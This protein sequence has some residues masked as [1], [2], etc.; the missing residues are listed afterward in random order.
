MAAASAPRPVLQEASGWQ[1]MAKKVQH[2]YDY[3][4]LWPII[5]FVLGF[6]NILFA[7]LGMIDFMVP[8]LLAL[9]GGNK[10]FCNRYCGRGLL[11]AKLGGDWKWS[12]NRA[13]PELLVAKWFRFGFLCFFMAMFGN[14]LWQTYLVATQA[15]SLREVVTLLWTF[16]LPWAWAYT[17]GSSPAWVAQYAFGFYSVML[18]SMLL[19]LAVMALFKPRTW[20]TFCPMGTMT[21]MICK[22]KR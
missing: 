12:R 5:Y 9:F 13:T 16:K 15:Q 10:L 2:W 17:A 22:M 14:M 11:L 18:T 1:Q 6:F 21:Q 4:L 3:L 20:C 8:V 7:W 19:G